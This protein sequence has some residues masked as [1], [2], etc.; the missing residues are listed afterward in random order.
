MTEASGTD[1]HEA[2]SREDRLLQHGAGAN[3]SPSPARQHDMPDTFEEAAGKLM[4]TVHSR[5]RME[6]MNW[7]GETPR[8]DDI[9]LLMC[10]FAEHLAFSVVHDEA[11]TKKYLDP[12]VLVKWGVSFDKL[13]RVAFE[14]LAA[15]HHEFG[16]LRKTP[17]IYASKLGD[18]YDSA[19]IVLPEVVTQCEVIGRDVVMVPYQDE[20]FISGDQDTDGLRIMIEYAKARP[21]SPAFIG[22]FAYRLRDDWRQ[23]D[24]RG[25]WQPWIPN[26]NH[27]LHEDFRDLATQALV[28]YY[29]H[30]QI[31]LHEAEDRKPEGA[32][33]FVASVMKFDGT[34]SPIRTCSA[35]SAGLQT[36]LPKTDAIA[37]AKDFQPG[38]LVPWSVVARTMRDELEPVGLYPERYRVRGY[39]TAGQLSAMVR[40]ARKRG[41]PQG[42]GTPR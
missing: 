28:A 3:E 13:F 38:G 37:F 42:R 12:T 4:L 39:P 22:G 23:C 34:R 2:A 30:Q 35:W 17:G 16:W 21:S 32:Q 15:L 7:S 26:K 9:R 1:Y 25:I 10:P 24:P 36:L 31:A 11:D 14:N 20:L 18:S 27:P 40:E 33:V 41:L 8:E 29:H 19:R 6:T 5:A